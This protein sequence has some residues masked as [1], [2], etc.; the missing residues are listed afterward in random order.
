MGE[1]RLGAGRKTR[2]A[3]S[4]SHRLSHVEVLELRRRASRSRCPGLVRCRIAAS[5]PSRADCQSCLPCQQ[6][7]AVCTADR[8]RSKSRCRSRARS[9]TA[10]RD[11]TGKGPTRTGNLLQFQ[12]QVIGGRRVDL[13][14]TAGTGGNNVVRDRHLT[15][16][17]G[18]DLADH[19]RRRSQPV[20]YRRDD[21]TVCHRCGDE[22]GPDAEQRWPECSPAGSW[23]DSGPSF[24][25]PGTA[26]RLAGTAGMALPRWARRR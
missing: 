10:Q 9:R 12:L 18:W 15:G 14:A 24:H 17:C 20:G 6:P 5:A 13:I 11:V 16:E 25:S 22:P 1:C 26:S 4:G 21:G 8:C 7:H 19:R 2:L 23:C 3:R